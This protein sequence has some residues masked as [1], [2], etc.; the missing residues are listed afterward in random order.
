[1]L[2]DHHTLQRKNHGNYLR[3]PHSNFLL[4]HQR[5]QNMDNPSNLGWGTSL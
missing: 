3:L 1:L 2:Q 4:N 5:I